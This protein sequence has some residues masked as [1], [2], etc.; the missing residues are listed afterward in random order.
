MGNKQRQLTHSHKQKYTGMNLLPRPKPAIT[1]ISLLIL[2]RR[3]RRDV[4]VMHTSSKLCDDWLMNGNAPQR[5]MKKK[6]H[7]VMSNLSF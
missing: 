2:G 1:E 4:L 5:E 7:V 3:R 6:Q